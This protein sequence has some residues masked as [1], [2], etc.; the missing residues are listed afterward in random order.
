AKSDVAELKP[1]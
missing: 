1:R